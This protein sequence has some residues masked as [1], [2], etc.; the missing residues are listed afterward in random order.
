MRFSDCM[1]LATSKE[2]EV[3]CLD[4]ILTFPEAPSGSISRGK[5][6]DHASDCLSVTNAGPAELI[7]RELGDESDG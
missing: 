7:S 6:S 2:I 1:M 3:G 4:R 5:R